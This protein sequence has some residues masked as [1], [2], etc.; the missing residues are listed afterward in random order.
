MTEEFLQ[1]IWA[2]AL[3]DTRHLTTASGH[4]VEVL[5]PGHLNHDAGPDF[6]NA[7]LRVGDTIL[8]GN[9]EIH[10]CATDWFRHGHHTD[11]AYDNVILS[12]AGKADVDVYTSKARRVDALELHP[13]PLLWERYTQLQHRATIPRCASSL[14]GIDPLR[15]GMMLTAYAIERLHDK[16]HTIAQSLRD[17]LDDWE[18]CFYQLL[19]RY[20]SGSVNADAFTL[21]ARQLPYKILLRSAA[22]PLQVEALLFGVSGLLRDAPLDDHV[23]ALREEYDFQASKHRLTSLDPSVWKFTRARPVSFPTVRLALLAAL[24]PRFNALFT[25]ILEAS[26]VR[27]IEHLLSVTA[28]SYWDTRYT[29]GT[30]APLRVK[31]LGR[32]MQHVIIINAVIPLLFLYG[33]RQ[34]RE[35]LSDKALRWLEALPAEQNHITAAWT[36]AG[37]PLPSALHSQAV[38]QIHKA[39]CEPRR[40]LQ[41]KF[42]NT[43]AHE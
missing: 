22:S 19:L 26:S 30:P 2:N 11:P 29:L 41:C 15:S 35:E 31:R 32:S 27:D 21:L 9:V 18:T 28:P 38:I 39:Y 16:C 12:V 34:S 1:Y 14:P 13:D 37:V 42:F 43:R 25:S 20:W 36:R 7:R 8:A 33:K 17:T 24:V 3:F 5:H 40:C 10:L 4:H 6:F 23:R